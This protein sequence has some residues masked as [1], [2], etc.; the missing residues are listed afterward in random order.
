MAPRSATR[1]QR[2]IVWLWRHLP[3]SGIAREIIA[4]AINLRYAIGVAAV[5][6]NEV[7]EVLLLQH[8]YLRGTCEWGLPGG[9]AKGREPLERALIREMHEETGFE[10]SVTRLVAIHS[11]YGVPRVTVI[12]RAHIAGG[13]FRPSAEVTDYGYFPSD[14]LDMI[15]PG[16]Q[17][18]VREAMQHA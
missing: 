8:T 12:Y 3:L 1:R 15:L 9:W 14:K 2:L 17:R 4:W 18:A 10:I 13:S 11:G 6:S 5:I 16:E 7:D